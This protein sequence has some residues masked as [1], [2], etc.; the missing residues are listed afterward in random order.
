[1][2]NENSLLSQYTRFR[3]EQPD[4]IL[5]IQVGGF[6]RIYEKDALVAST[7]LCLKIIPQ[8]MNGKVPSCGFPITSLTKHIDLLNFNGYSVAICNQ[9]DEEIEGIKS[10]KVT[11][12]MRPNEGSLNASIAGKMPSDEEYESYLTDFRNKLNN[13]AQALKTMKKSAALSSE[14]IEELRKIDLDGT[15]PQEA[16]AIL[17]HWQR[18]YCPQND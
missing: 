9:L 4:C 2:K 6:Y 3:V 17:Y 15:P 10:R 13:D 1:M 7:I 8:D 18:K 14:I 11:D 5:I 16:W 12:I